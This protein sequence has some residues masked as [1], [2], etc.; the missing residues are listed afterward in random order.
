MNQTVC[1]ISHLILEYKWN[2]KK[3]FTLSSKN[4]NRSALQAPSV[5]Q[6]YCSRSFTTER[7][8]ICI[9]T[10]IKLSIFC[11]SFYF[12]AFSFSFHS[13]QV[14]IFT[15]RS[16]ELERCDLSL[17]KTL[18]LLIKG[19]THQLGLRSTTARYLLPRTVF[20][21]GFKDLIE[22]DNI[23]LFLT[24]WLAPLVPEVSAKVRLN[25]NTANMSQ[26]TEKKPFSLLFFVS[27]RDLIFRLGFNI[28]STG[29]QWVS[30]SV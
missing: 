22:L 9:M 27:V 24:S 26:D 25:R 15:L 30:S 23:F 4:I 13:A 19:H 6:L 21:K 14:I 18:E 2:I 5:P 1:F 20:L 12:L 16:T 29:T 7:A 10:F 8:V 17:W 28:K 3:C 11:L